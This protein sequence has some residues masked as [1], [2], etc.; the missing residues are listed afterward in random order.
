MARKTIDLET[1][2]VEANNYFKFS[3]NDLRAERLVLRSFVSGLLS[4]AGA[5]KGFRYL[6]ETDML[7]SNLTHGIDV[8][9][10]GNH[11]YPDDSRIAFIS[12]Y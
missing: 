11:T 5:Y 4:K 3:N 1:I 10:T 9:E 8:S 7:G 12:F 6:T 2:K